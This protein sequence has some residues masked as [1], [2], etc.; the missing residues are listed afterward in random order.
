MYK[1]IKCIRY[2]YI[3]RSC[4]QFSVQ[5]RD[6]SSSSQKSGGRA[7][8]RDPSTPVRGPRTYPSEVLWA[9][10]RRLQVHESA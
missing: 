8:G 4:R 5:G 7:Q 10:P 2:K 6:S 3:W 1:Y 9:C